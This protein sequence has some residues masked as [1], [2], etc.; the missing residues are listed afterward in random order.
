MPRSSPTPPSGRFAGSCPLLKSVNLACCEL[1]T[2]TSIKA[3][4]GS[5]RRI[6]LLETVNLDYCELL[7][8]VSVIALAKCPLL[9]FVSLDECELITHA[10]IAALKAALPN[11]ECWNP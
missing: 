4:A 7:T 2:D 3:L 5:C 6:P 10:S 8:D 9:K 11:V 1:L